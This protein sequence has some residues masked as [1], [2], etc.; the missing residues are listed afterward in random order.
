VAV[1]VIPTPEERKVIQQAKQK[2]LTEFAIEESVAYGIMR[3]VS[4]DRGINMLELAKGILSSDK[5]FE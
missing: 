3:K 5:V 2:L 4:M 1:S